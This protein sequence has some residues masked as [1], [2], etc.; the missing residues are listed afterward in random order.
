ML[1]AVYRF[2]R[3][4][5]LRSSRL[6][7]PLLVLFAYI[8]IAYAVAPLNI[9]SSFSICSIVLFILML[10]IGMM[11]DHIGYAMIEQ[12]ILV[13]LR[14]KGLFYLG[15]AA[16]MAAVSLVFAA[17]AVLAPVLI[18]LSRGGALF[19]RG[20]VVADVLSGFV[21]FALTGLCGGVTGLFAHHRIIANRKIAI[22]VCIAFALLTVIK[23]AMNAQVEMLKYVTWILPPVH[24][25]SVAYSKYEYFRFEATWSYFLWLAGYIG[26]EVLAYVAILRRRGVE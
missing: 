8:G 25:L 24:D 15:K 10:S 12:T 5:L 26:I 18:D 22:L 2:E 3:D 11:E 23:G 1:K 19:S 9:M 4:K 7:V 14:R 17:L 13:R 6:I 21:L 16:L 20:I